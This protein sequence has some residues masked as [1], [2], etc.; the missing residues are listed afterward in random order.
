[1]SLFVQQKIPFQSVIRYLRVLEPGSETPADTWAK[2]HTEDASVGDILFVFDPV[3][4]PWGDSNAG[5][6][7]CEGDSFTVSQLFMVTSSDEEGIS[8]FSL[9]NDTYERQ[10]LLTFFGQAARAAKGNSA[11]Y[12]YAIVRPNPALSV[13]AIQA[14][15][16]L[17]SYGGS[18]WRSD[19]A[20]MPDLPYAFFQSAGFGVE[21]RPGQV[22][23]VSQLGF[24]LFCDKE[25]PSGGALP[26][27]R[28]F[29]LPVF[30][31][32]RLFDRSSD[33][34]FDPTRDVETT[35]LPAIP[36]SSPVPKR[37]SFFSQMKP[38][39]SSGTAPIQRVAKP[40]GGGSVF[41]HDGATPPVPIWDAPEPEPAPMAYTEPL[42]WGE[43]PPTEESTNPSVGEPRVNFWMPEDAVITQDGMEAL[44][45]AA[46]E[47]LSEAPVEVPPEPPMQVPSIRTPRIMPPRPNAGSGL[48]PV[49]SRAVSHL[50][51]MSAQLS[52]PFVAE[53]DVVLEQPPSSDADSKGYA[54]PLA[55]YLEPVKSPDVQ[56]IMAAIHTSI[57]ESEM[58]KVE[59]AEAP[60]AARTRP[61]RSQQTTQNQQQEQEVEEPKSDAV[62]FD[63]SQIAPLPPKKKKPELQESPRAQEIQNRAQLKEPLAVKSGVAGLV[64][65]L[66]QQASKASAKLESQVDEIQNKL[67]EELNSLT[68]KITGSERRSAKS[69]EGLRI[70]LTSK[71]EH[72]ATEVKTQVAQSAAVGHTTIKQ[73][74]DAGS[75][76][77]G[78]KHEYLRTSLNGSFDEVRARAETVSKSFEESMGTQSQDALCAL[79]ETR[80]KMRGEFA[81]V[82]SHYEQC[83]QTVF[84]SYKGRLSSVS[85][86]MSQAVE[87]RCGVLEAQLDD[88]RQRNLN[89]LENTKRSLLSRLNKQIILAESELLKLQTSS[90][91]ESVMPKF[92]QQREELRVVTTEFQLK[93]SEDLHSKGE[94][95]VADFQPV[96]EEKKEKLLAL[97]KETTL[98][99][100]SIQDQLRSRME[101]IFGELKEFVDQSIEQAQTAYTT[102]EEQLADIDRSIRA[103]ADPLTI[104]DDVELLNERGSVLTGLDEI[105]EQAK[106]DVLN[107]LRASVAALEEKGK[108]L[109]EELISSMEEDAYLVRRASEQSLVAIREAIRDSFVAIQAAQDERMPM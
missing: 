45:A 106:E 30:K 97:L 40:A 51:D 32:A 48:P 19:D 1:M 64:S 72:A 73:R 100:D 7:V 57:Q 87:T 33:P 2:N 89:V 76:Q 82:Q 13:E 61:G 84:D 28:P 11:G 24:A 58:D 95:K 98:V 35:S 88:L 83:M 15:T 93:L 85:G 80:E 108:H 46:M 92:R 55:S 60:P 105:T 10:L 68:N 71:M 31:D 20:A 62:A 22:L 27:L 70:N 12:Y 99:K 56:D 47:A 44:T 4:S 54:P 18:G 26:D 86:A 107:S 17:E 65:K 14:L 75:E 36:S 50:N 8:G 16:T 103:L 37:P 43:D 63:V 59:D 9:R 3:Y 96:L 29:T 53:A 77:L 69:A 94:T 49:P 5:I 74:N 79:E 101:S 41:G 66:E 81:E 42:I 52:V 23:D 38:G 21:A 91:E 67:N 90:L 25:P 104:E 78:E 34:D 109:Q 102:T 6:G 39:I